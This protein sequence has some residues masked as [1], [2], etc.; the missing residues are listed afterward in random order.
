MHCA[1]VRPDRRT[2]CTRVPRPLGG[3]GASY[4]RRDDSGA[5]LASGSSNMSPRFR[6]LLSVPTDCPTA[7]AVRRTASGLLRSVLD[8]A[9][10]RMGAVCRKLRSTDTY[11]PTCRCV[12]T[13]VII[14]WLSQYWYIH[15]VVCLLFVCLRR[16]LMR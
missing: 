15:C 16:V 12:G 1:A 14:S 2:P 4:L 5:R 8:G 7:R 6:L 10:M 11:L 9:P 13:Y 3:A